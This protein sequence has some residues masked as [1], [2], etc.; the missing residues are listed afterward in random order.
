M[1]A[2]LP[3]SPSSLLSTANG[4]FGLAPHPS[5]IPPLLYRI[6]LPGLWKEGGNDDS[7]HPKKRGKSVAY[8]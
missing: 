3:S 4:R 7:T 2:Q 6:I 1:T 8:K 5:T